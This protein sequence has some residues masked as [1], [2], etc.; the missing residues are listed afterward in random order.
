MK[1]KDI[2]LIKGPDVFTIG[3][4]KT[5]K[6]ALQTLINNNIGVLP[7]INDEAKLVGILSERDIL[8]KVNTS[9]DDFLSLQ[10]DDIMTK[11]IIYADYEDDID[12]IE[13]VMTAN[14]FRHLPIMKNNI[15]VGLISIGD[16]VKSSLKDKKYENKYMLEYIAGNVM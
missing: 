8:R 5:V 15:L 12:Y 6:E 3:C 13:S 4:K 2:L 9:P 7:V 11:R 14:K 1:A 16:I 10:V